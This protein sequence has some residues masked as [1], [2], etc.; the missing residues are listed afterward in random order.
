MSRNQAIDIDKRKLKL[1]AS[2]LPEIKKIF[3]NMAKDAQNLY[4]AGSLNPKELAD[5]YYNEFVKDIRD[6]MRRA[7]KEFGYDM[8]DK[9]EKKGFDFNLSLTKE[10]LGLDVKLKIDQ[11]GLKPKMNK[12]NI[13]FQKE[14][15]L[16]IA[17]ESE[18][19]ARYI[20]NT[21]A[22]EINFVIMQEELKLTKAF[23]K[24]ERAIIARNIFINLLDRKDERADLIASQ[25][26]GMTESY[27]RFKEAEIVHDAK[28]ESNGTIIG[29]TKTWWAILDMKTRPE[30]VSADQQ[31]VGIK[32]NFFVNGENLKMPRD[33]NGS[34][35]NVINCRCVANFD[36]EETKSFKAISDI[37]LKPTQEMANE[38]E[39]GLKWREEFKRGGTLVG[40]ARANQLKNRE[41]LTPK[42]IGRMVSYFAR[43]EVDKEAEGFY[44]GEDGFP[45]AGRIA[46]QLWGGDVGKTWANNKWKQ[47]KREK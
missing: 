23:S 5:N 37:D 32:D 11:E 33:P 17:N 3:R 28:I 1:E 4:E 22:N 38:A 19:Q 35:G 24:E 18:Q 12:I 39:Q 45:S 29:A 42:T 16:F 10:L 2:Y 9:L 21:N 26:V 36:L 43:H 44:S 27:S 14:M 30:H 15:T 47:I 40:V 13:E 20:T 6:I 8:R 25:V 7:V 34:A 46:W 31:M 41:N